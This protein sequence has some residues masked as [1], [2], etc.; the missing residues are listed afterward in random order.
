M[1]K[2]FHRLCPPL[3]VNFCRFIEIVIQT[4]F[5]E[6][7]GRRPLRWISDENVACTFLLSESQ[8]IPVPVIGWLCPLLARQDIAGMVGLTEDHSPSLGSHGSDNLHGFQRRNLPPSC[9]LNGYRKG[10]SLR[11][12]FHILQFLK[13]WIKFSY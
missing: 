8:D 9:G 4:L 5:S 1:T 12:R 7:T 10:G 6:V 11:I 3:A 2:F 13:R